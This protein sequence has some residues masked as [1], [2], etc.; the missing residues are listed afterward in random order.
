[1]ARRAALL[2]RT[3]SAEDGVQVAVQTIEASMARR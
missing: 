1:M 3:M 2:G